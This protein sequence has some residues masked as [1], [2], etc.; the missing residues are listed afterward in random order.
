MF[1]SYKG[2]GTV[3]QRIGLSRPNKRLLVMMIESLEAL[4]RAAAWTTTT[5]KHSPFL[6]LFFVLLVCLVRE[7]RIPWRAF[8]RRSLARSYVTNLA[9][10]LFND[11]V[12]SLLSLPSLFYVA[13]SFS[14]HGLLSRMPEG[15]WKWLLSFVLL[16]LAMYVWHVANHRFEV[17][18]RFHKVHHSDTTLNATTGLRFHFGELMLTVLVKAGFIVLVGVSAQL[19]IINEIILSSFVIFHHMN[20]SPWGEKVF[21]TLFI[22][23]RLHRLHHSARRDEHDHNYGGALSLWDKLFG[24]LREGEPEAIGLGNVKEQGFWEMLRFGL[25]AYY[26]RP[27]TP[28]RET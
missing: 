9:T 16:D 27:G 22:M 12:L 15:P 4:S 25:I 17:L 28:L 6:L 11:T 23:P 10:F 21:G 26:N 7:L 24:T 19:V 5:L 14:G 20:S 8:S 13:Q 1:L 3:R 18:W 2:L